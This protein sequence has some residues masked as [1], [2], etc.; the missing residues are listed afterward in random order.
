VPVRGLTRRIFLGK[1]RDPLDP[2]IFH[3]LSLA[4]FLAWVGLGADGL[5]SSCYG[6]EEAFHALGTH[7]HLAIFLAAATAVTIFVISASYA[8]II[9][10][11]P[12]GGGGYLV[13]TRLLGEGA[14]LVS[15]AAL[16]VDYALTIA[17]SV[18][19]GVAALSSE[20]ISRGVPPGTRLLLSVLIV[21]GLI[22]LNL[23]GMKESVQVLLP[24]FLV[25]LATHAAMLLFGIG[26]HTSELPQL[27]VETVKDTKETWSALG[28]FGMIALLLKAFSMGGGTYTGIEAVSNGLQI[29]REPRVRTGKRTMLYMAV[30]LSITAG[31]LLLCYLLA[32]VRRIEGQTLNAVLVNKLAPEA[33]GPGAAAAGFALVTLVSE[34]ALLFVAAQA[35]FLDGP[36]VLANMAIDSWVP[37][38]FSLLSERLVTQNGVLVMGLSAIGMLLFTGG[39]VDVIVVMYS[40]N[41]FLTFSL[42]QLGMCVHWWQE[43]H[44]EPSWWRRFAINGF[45]LILTS[46][47]LLVTVTLKF[48]EG[49]WVTVVITGSFIALC[50]F[51]RRHYLSVGLLMKRADDVLTTLPKPKPGDT[52]SLP[53]VTR[54]MPTAVFLVSGFNGLGIHSLLQVQKYFPKH[55]KNAVFLSV[56]V[57]DSAKF[58]GVDAV[59]QLRQET[60]RDLTKYVEFAHGLGMH[61]EHH[62]A[63]GTD[64]LDEIVV[65]CQRVKERYDRPVFFASKLIFPNENLA[66]RLLHNQTPFAVQRRLQF[67]GLQTVILPIQVAI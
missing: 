42:S 11:F 62:Y 41:V 2:R 60:E 58:K 53:A 12:T 40:I 67:E 18:A 8:Q 19:A 54:N 24:I 47:I 16:V 56:G 44:T 55:F 35:G 30:S 1:S 23:R 27:A 64:L 50:V 63:I 45:G 25:F 26:R 59:E 31:G 21:V 10:F 9:E 37:H 32:N 38:R 66:N 3:Q 39:S 51:C 22:V 7:T 65:L 28:A 52:G 34:G 14:G 57:V 15:G 5:S 46:A 4:A 20:P 61:A 6:P 29:L 13:A 49:G 48:R 33:F 43:R 36:R 17:M